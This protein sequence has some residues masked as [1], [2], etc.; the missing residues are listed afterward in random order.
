MDT[1]FEALRILTIG[2]FLIYGVHCLISRAMRAEFERYGLARW[3][4]LTGWLEIVGALGLI[5]SY[6]LPALAAFAA[7]GLALLM[8]LGIWTRVRIQDP[9]A[10]MVPALLFLGVNAWISIYV[11]CTL[12]V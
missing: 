6:W 3:R 7:A 9:V 2:A 11:A 12:M 5:G 10:A 1:A 8:V 4:R